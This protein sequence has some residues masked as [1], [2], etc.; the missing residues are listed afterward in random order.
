MKSFPIDCFELL[1]HYEYRIYTY[2]ELKKK[3]TELYEMCV[4]YSEDAFCDGFTK[5]IAYNDNRPVG[6]IRFSLMH[7]LGHHILNHMG[8]SKRNE[9]EA[10]TFASYI[11]APRMAIH[12]SGCKNANDVSK[13]FYLSHEAASHAFDGYRR[14]HRDIM[15]HK[16]TRRDKI[17]YDHFYNQSQQCFVWSIKKRDICDKNLYNTAEARYHICTLPPVYPRYDFSADSLWDENVKRL[18]SAHQ[19]WLY[20]F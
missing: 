2:K 14:W 5:I 6:R 13:I 10:N 8:E 11:L 15:I 16:M 7:E 3:N 1:N 4:G 12:Y 20:D 18:H 9:Y 19:K 17:M